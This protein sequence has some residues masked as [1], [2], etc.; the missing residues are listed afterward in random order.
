MVKS[1]NSER[2]PKM[3]EKFAMSHASR[4]QSTALTTIQRDWFHMMLEMKIL[5]PGS[6]GVGFGIKA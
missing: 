6:S 3:D 1:V 2:A 5:V 4:C